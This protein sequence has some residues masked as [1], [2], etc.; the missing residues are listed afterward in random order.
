MPANL[1]DTVLTI[2]EDGKLIIA[3]GD[4]G[5][6]V[7]L[8]LNSRGQL[9]LDG[10]EIVTRNT[11]VLTRFQIAVASIGAA[12]ALVAGA[13]GLVTLLERFGVMQLVF[14]P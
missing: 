5:P 9:L 8:Q 1:D 2:G 10:K 6:A 12:A 11:L 14:T 4:Q 3:R 13:N 7:T